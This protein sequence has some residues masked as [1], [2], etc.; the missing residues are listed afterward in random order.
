M[1]CR[2][3][4][5]RHGETIWNATMRY[6][7]HTDI[8]LSENGLRQAEMLSKKLAGEKISSFYASDLQRAYR[9]AEILAAPYGLPVVKT[10]A[11]RELNFGVWE[12]LTAKQIKEGYAQMFKEWWSAPLTTRISEGETLAEVV[13]RCLVT[14]QEIVSRHKGEQV[15]VVSH[16][17][18]I[19]CIVGSVLGMNLNQYWRL[20]LDNTAL[21]II[22]FPEWDKGILALYNDCSHLS[23]LDAADLQT[24]IYQETQK[25]LR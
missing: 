7:G 18:T 5:V 23:E 12:G 15:V 25:H 21:S 10:A 16:G 9:T 1:S 24:R 3:F 6:Q 14:L 11:L 8:P 17:G 13:E 2:V 22:D 19:R 20:R 4:L